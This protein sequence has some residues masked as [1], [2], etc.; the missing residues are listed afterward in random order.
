MS[1]RGK[2]ETFADTAKKWAGVAWKRGGRVAWVVAAT[3][4][5][6]FLPLVMEIEREGSVIETDKLRIKDFRAQGYT[7]NQIS[8]M[9]LSASVEPAVGLAAPASAKGAPS[10][11]VTSDGPMGA[12]G[13]PPCRAAT[14]L[15]SA[16]SASRERSRR[17]RRSSRLCG[18]VHP[19]AGCAA[20]PSQPPPRAP[21]AT[22]APHRASRPLRY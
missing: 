17:E 22:A 21:P 12:I 16:S 15:R 3:S 6:M 1:L 2:L 10:S 13:P 14:A 20:R 19:S 9:G 4:I 18:R 11:R 5:V 8:Q 7:D